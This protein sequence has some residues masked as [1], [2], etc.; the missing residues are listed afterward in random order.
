MLKLG[1]SIAAL[2]LSFAAFGQGQSQILTEDFNNGTSMPTG[3]T[4]N[5]QATDGGWKAGTSNALSSSYFSIPSTGS[6]IVATNDDDC[7][8]NK[9]AD[10]LISAPI[11]LSGI[12]SAHVNFKMYYFHASYQGAQENA[13][14][15]YS[16]DGSNWTTVQNITSGSSDWQDMYFDISNA[17]GNDSVW[18]AFRYGDGGGWNYGM[19]IEDLVVY[20]PYNYDFTTTSIDLYPVQGLNN[21]PFTISGE[22]QNIGGQTVNSLDINYQ[23]NNTGT[24]YTASLTNLNL[25]PFATYQFSHTTTWTPSST[26]TYTLEAWASNL[27]GTT[28]QNTSNDKLSKQIQVVPSTVQRQVLVEEFTSSTCPPCATFNAQFT[29][30]INA[31]NPNSATGKINVVKYQMNWPSPGTDPNYNQ[32]GLGRRTYYGVSGV[33]NPFMDANDGFSSQAQIDALYD[34]P[35][36]VVLSGVWTYDGNS[37]QVTVDVDPKANLSG[38]LKLRIAVVEKEIKVADFPGYPVTNGESEF[39]FVMRKMLPNSNGI[40]LGNLTANQTSSHYES[41][42]FTI[43]GVAQNNSNIWH[44]MDDLEVVAWIQD[45]SDKSILQSVTLTAQGIGIDELDAVANSINIYPN[46][47]NQVANIEVDLKNDANVLITLVNGMGQV[48]VT[49]ES[50]M[51]AGFNTNSIDVSN[52][53]AGVYMLQLNIDGVSVTKRIAITR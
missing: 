38:N 10:W 22:I 33:P 8:C 44:T 13:A 17:T 15:L 18:L 46:P 53:A 39:H 12:S 32:D 2:A 19:A 4:Q 45:D 31:N 20:V 34:I 26:G 5:T 50:N 42:M 47:A 3:W 6:N 21:A 16:T 40:N 48:V 27:D 7:N 1:T 11:D 9:S 25:A 30:I 51:L 49:E 36:L 28:D 41:H 52:L 24:V 35:A 43:G 23:I 14:F 37:I 29:P